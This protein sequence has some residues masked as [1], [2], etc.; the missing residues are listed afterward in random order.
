MQDAI[1]EVNPRMIILSG[2][3]NSVHA[4]GAPL[5]P[6]EFYTYCHSSGIPLLGICYGMQVSPGLTD[7]WLCSILK[8][9][10]ECQRQ[11]SPPAH[12]LP[13][14]PRS[15]LQLLVH[16]L[17][18]VVQTVMDSGEYGRMPINVE[19]DSVLYAGEEAD[20]QLVWMSHGDSATALPEGFRAVAKSEQVPVWV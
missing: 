11:R 1:K 9:V 6:P 15:T 5:L 3:P 4:E 10:T 2:G 17:G 7:G 13:F 20:R 12:Q 14:N 16:Q 8:R 18:G 19:R